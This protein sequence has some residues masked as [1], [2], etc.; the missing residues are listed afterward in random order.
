MNDKTYRTQKRRLKALAAKWFKCLGLLWWKI[1]ISYDRTGEAFASKGKSEGVWCGIALVAANWEYRLAKMTWNMPLL[2]EL[3]DAELEGKFLHECGHIL[4]REMREWAVEG[5][6]DHAVQH[7]ERVVTG[8]ENA[9]AWVWAEATRV[10]A[11]PRELRRRKRG[12]T[13]ARPATRR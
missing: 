7:E 1:S 3:N 2:P 10:A 8:L 11:K 9:F 6:T 13:R 5:S 4:V 12:V